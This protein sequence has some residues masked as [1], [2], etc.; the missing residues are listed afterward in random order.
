[1]QLACLNLSPRMI[2]IR[3]FLI[4]WYHPI[5]LKLRFSRD[6]L[7]RIFYN[8]TLMGYLIPIRPCD[9]RMK[10]MSNP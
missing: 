4:N 5:I 9:V 6:M 10:L 8:F 1:M 2:T 7:G 3:R